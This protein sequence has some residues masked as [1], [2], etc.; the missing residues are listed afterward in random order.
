VRGCWENKREES[1]KTAEDNNKAGEKGKDR[2]ARAEE[3]LGI[4]SN[5][6]TAKQSARLP[7]TERHKHRCMKSAGVGETRPDG[8]TVADS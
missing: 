6:K 3:L 4:Y 1:L 2:E 8:E 7:T 5:I